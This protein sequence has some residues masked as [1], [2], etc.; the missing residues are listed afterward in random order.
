[1]RLFPDQR[2]DTNGPPQLAP[3]DPRAA[4]DFVEA[5]ESSE[6]DS[7][8]PGPSTARTRVKKKKSSPPHSESDEDEEDEE[9]AGDSDSAV[10]T[11]PMTRASAKKV[12]KP[13]TSKP[14]KK[15]VPILAAT[16]KPQKKAVIAT[17]GSV[18]VVESD[19]SDDERV[20]PAAR[21]LQR[22]AQV[23]SSNDSDDKSVPST[24]TVAIKQSPPDQ[25]SDD[26]DE[27]VQIHPPMKRQIARIQSPE[28]SAERGVEPE[29]PTPVGSRM[30]HSALKLRRSLV[31]A[32]KLPKFSLNFAH[33]ES[34][35]RRAAE[36]SKATDAR[37]STSKAAPPVPDVAAT[38][39][40]PESPT[41]VG[42]ST[43]PILKQRKSLIAG[44]KL[45][46]F[47]L[48]NSN[49][50]PGVP[51]RSA[52]LSKP[53]DA[54]SL[55]SEAALPDAE[56]AVP[57]H[58]KK[59]HV[60]SSSEV[61]PKAALK[62]AVEGLPLTSEAAPPDAP[63]EAAGPKRHKTK[64]VASS[65]KVVPKAAPKPAAEG[66][67]STSEAVPPDAEGA[68]AKRHR[69]KHVASSS[70]VV[71]KGL[72]STSKAVPP[73]A[74]ALSRNAT[75]RSMALSRSL[76]TKNATTSSTGEA[77]T[78]VEATVA[79]SLTTKGAPNA[80]P[81]RSKPT[82]KHVSAVAPP[83]GVAS[84]L[85]IG[86]LAPEIEPAAKLGKMKC[87]ATSSTSEVSAKRSKTKHAT[88]STTEA[89]RPRQSRNARR[90]RIRR[91]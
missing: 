36:A 84:A 22:K 85:S 25:P 44:G 38:I 55:A 76:K 50:E 33:P 69:T 90:Q 75:R 16:S 64:R 11:R 54:T 68:V 42:L 14:R 40:E 79:D 83:E 7:T 26:E 58:H 21:K 60:A 1:M 5:M 71:P 9:S 34:D 86:E 77:A 15:A 2:V 80:V 18:E 62:S 61:A 66:L 65:S 39:A 48:C 63:T 59:K 46:A 32:G 49:P 41:P 53:A 70:E 4:D 43:S 89:A 74:E 24:A 12:A 67:S 6:S 73:D 37:S 51:Q 28:S 56:A 88:G 87:F 45:M 78:P 82:Q 72:S 81:E 91:R 30:G 8:K 57:K 47:N 29:T 27:Q 13:V 20:R 52:A 3:G 31:V 19:D 35:S 17:G 23:V 10:A